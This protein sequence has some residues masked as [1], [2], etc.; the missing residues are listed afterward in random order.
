MR[1]GP[2]RRALGLSADVDRGCHQRKVGRSDV[3][4]LVLEALVRVL[5]GSPADEQ[6]V[7]DPLLVPG[8]LSVTDL[9]RIFGEH[10]C[11]PE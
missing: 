4:V 6:V 8:R 2:V 11:S 10:L 9:H 7:M 1:H 3:L 5:H